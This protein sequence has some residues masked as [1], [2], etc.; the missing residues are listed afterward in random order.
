MIGQTIGNYRLLKVLGEGG[1]GVVYEAEHVAMGRRA[2]VKMMLA[3]NARDEKT[4][5]R[6]FNE[7]RATNE[8]RHPGI[9]QIY[10]CGTA[11]DGAPWL[12]MELLEGETLGARLARLGRLSVAETVDLGGQAASVLAAAHAAG[13]VHRDLKPDNLFV[14]PDPAAPSGARVKVLDF[15]IAKLA[16]RDP[17]NAL[18]TQTGVLM[19]TP[20]YMS[21][22]QCRGTKQ[23][24]FRSDIYS[25]GLIVYQMLAGA[26][27]FVSEGL[28]ELLHMHMNV[29]AAPLSEHNPAVGPALGTAIARVIEKDPAARHASMKAFQEALATAITLEQPR[30]SGSG[31]TLSSS[32][33]TGSITAGTTTLSANAGQLEQGPDADV[34]VIPRRG[35]AGIV[36]ALVIVLG[37]AGTFA[38][39]ALRPPG[40]DPAPSPL[41]TGVPAPTGPARTAE[42]PPEDR[43]VTPPPPAQ[44]ARTTI[45]IA[46]APAQARLLDAGDGHLLGTSPWHGELP[47]GPGEL[48]VRVEK[49]G[50]KSLMIS[51]PLDQAF[52]RTIELERAR[53]GG[54]RGGGASGERIIKL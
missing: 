1:M 40:V 17:V 21:P 24:D 29:R 43:A 18:R 31:V 37:V 4:I 41:T 45:D 53:A 49:A 54:R 3:Q 39:R 11:T 9:V 13:I 36:A 20:L 33:R 52:N 50:Y 42:P 15:G 44:P 38:V 8:V 46:T 35:R 6:F 47:S 48:K 26:P 27:P 25:L 34:V 22:E 2:A 10:D 32:G 16:A 14:V 12:I 5:Q 30:P 28:G 19:G 23:V 51:I 7:A